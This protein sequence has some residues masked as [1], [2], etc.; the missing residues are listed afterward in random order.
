MSSKKRKKRSSATQG[1]VR[2]PSAAQSI[3]RPPM[4]SASQSTRALPNQR[5]GTPHMAID[6]VSSLKTQRKLNASKYQPET[7]TKASIEQ[8][9]LVTAGTSH[10]DLGIRVGTTLTQTGGYK[11]VNHKPL[12]SSRSSCDI[13]RFS[14]PTC[15]TATK[16]KVFKLELPI[17]TY[18]SASP[19]RIPALCNSTPS[20]A[21]LLCA[22][23]RLTL[24]QLRHLSILV[25]LLQWR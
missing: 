8:Q 13:L 4:P 24:Q 17:S 20:R 11:L 12:S 23:I 21:D 6:N 3:S 18:A 9:Y 14:S 7:A 2:P 16:L 19:A 25:S 15:S 22:L 10:I 1:I 5:P